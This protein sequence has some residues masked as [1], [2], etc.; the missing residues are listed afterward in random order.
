MGI[1]TC[2]VIAATFGLADI[3][4]C[5]LTGIFLMTITHCLSLKDAYRS[6]ESEVLSALTIGRS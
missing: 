2:V 4:T 1:F 5:S 6:L 3:M